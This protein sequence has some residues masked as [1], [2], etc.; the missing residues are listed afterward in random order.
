MDDAA[1]VFRDA[2]E[3]FVPA[4]AAALERLLGCMR[5]RTVEAGQHVLR[6]G[7]R[8]TEVHLVLDG[9]LREYYLLDDG[10]ERTKSFVIEG[11]FAGSLPDLLSGRVARAHIVAG[12][13]TT[14]LVGD[15]DELT[16]RA[17]EHPST[18]GFVAEVL[19]RLLIT[20]ADREY[21][22]LALDAEGR[23]EAFS[24]RFP[25]LEGRIPARHIASYIGITPVHLSRVRRSRR[26]RSTP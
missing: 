3:A 19:R 26:G 24:R 20:K 10:T 2:V 1:A 14:L 18:R 4:E 12:G 9:L 17:S 5:R 22:L 16:A 25:D 23:Y 21:E 7:E 11:Q 15:F 6:A 13:T 8:A